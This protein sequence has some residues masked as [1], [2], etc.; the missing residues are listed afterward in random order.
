MN[1]FLELLKFSA[2]AIICFLVDFLFFQLFFFLLDRF[3][4]L[5]Y[6]DTVATYMARAISAPLNFYLNRKVVFKSDVSLVKSIL[7]YVFLALFIVVVNS[8]LAH[9]FIS[10]LGINSWLAKA[11]IES[12]LFVI[13][14]LIQHFIIFKK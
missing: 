2:S 3:A 13:N 7:Q 6:A 1:K 11:L 8:F 10:T 4:G 14:Y 12:I 9:L 5:S